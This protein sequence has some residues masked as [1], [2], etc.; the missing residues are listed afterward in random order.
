MTA[1]ALT[2]GGVALGVLFRTGLA[3]EEQR[4]LQVIRGHVAIAEELHAARRA[5]GPLSAT[6]KALIHSNLTPDH[7]F[8]RGERY[9]VLSRT[10]A[11]IAVELLRGASDEGAP[12]GDAAWA[13]WPVAER[14]F[15]GESGT[16]EGPD[17]RGVRVLGAFTPVKDLDLAVVAMT[18]LSAFRAPY[19]EAGFVVLAFAALVIALG[20]FV[21]MAVSEPIIRRLRDGEVRFHE[22]FNNMKGGAVVLAA[23]DSGSDFLVRDVNRSAEGLEERPREELVGK[24]FLAAMPEAGWTGLLDMVRRVWK[25]GVPESQPAMFYE[26]D[27]ISGWRESYVYRLPNGEVVVLLQDVTEEKRSEHGRRESEA[28]WRSVFERQSDATVIL[29]AS[30]RIVDVNAAAQSLFGKSAEDLVGQPFGFPVASNAPAEIEVIRP[31]GTVAF[32]EMQVMPL[33][34]AGQQQF[35]LF[36]RDISEHRRTQGDLRKLFQAIEQSPASVVITDIEGRIEYV[37]P[38]FTQATGYTYAEVVGKNPRVLKSGH[39]TGAEYDKLWKTISRGEVWRGEFHNRSKSGQ[40]FW[41]LA[42]IAPVRDVR[43]RITHFVAVKED[44][45]ERKATEERLRQVSKMKAIGELTGGI[46]HDFNNLLAI[47][48]GNLQLLDESLP[49]DDSRKELVT[50]AIWSAERGAQLTSRLLAFARRQ[51][52]QPKATDVNHVIARMTHLLRRTLG[53]RIAIREVFADDLWRVMIDRGQLENAIVNLVV[54][55]RD[56]MP[57]GGVLTITT[58][59]VPGGSHDGEPGASL[60]DA[61]LISVADTGCGMPPDVVERVFEPFFTTKSFGE[62]SG[63]GLSMVY[64][65]VTQSGGQITVESALGHGTTMRLFLPRD[66]AGPEAQAGI[67]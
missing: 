13:A 37:N 31:T 28:R 22:L 48:M 21:V 35:L 61:V 5:N 6:T 17:P 29:D 12:A 16:F 24:S 34:V 3:V 59:N 38:K 43:G 2:V 54:N 56:A 32:A 1:V 27:R 49:A 36:I 9:I 11:G 47:I 41:E 44:I 23:V 67:P 25:T 65:F 7:G 55:A 51:N 20:V 40:L 52:L 39:T 58:Q 45:T 33:E 60:A 63:L 4:L 26:D 15:A 46:A 8:N 66:T 53:D 14:A 57:D 64:G 30:H 10:A 18:D 19:V 42:A 62:G 50:D